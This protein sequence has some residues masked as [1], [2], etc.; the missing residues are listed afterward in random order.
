M[1]VGFIDDTKLLTAG[2]VS[3][4]MGALMIPMIYFL[5]VMIADR[6]VGALAALLLWLDPV[7]IICSQKVWMDT[8]V[9]FFTLLAVVFFVYAL[10]SS[11]DWFFIFCG[12]A[13]G[14][15]VN[16]KYTGI[17]ITFVMIIFAAF[18]R[19]DLFANKKFQLSLVLPILLLLPWFFW[20]YRVYGLMSVVQHKELM[21]F[22]RVLGE[23]FSR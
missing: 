3:L 22:L 8:S 18:Y 2:Y 5:G 14:L 23:A 19:K 9:A 7:S 15:A 13:S 6:K 11:N 17:L 12:V 20:N 21:R 10:K 4:L 16:T 1:K